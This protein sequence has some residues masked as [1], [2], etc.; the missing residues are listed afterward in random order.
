MKK[1]LICGAELPNAAPYCEADGEASF[2][3]TFEE[4][5][6]ETPTLPN[7]GESPFQFMAPS[8]RKGK[9]R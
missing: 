7:P 6:P 1:C 3:P 4:P 5:E 8:P 2:G 9:N